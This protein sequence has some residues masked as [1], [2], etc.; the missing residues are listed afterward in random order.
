MCFRA[1]VPSVN[2]L[3]FR[4]R[5]N[6]PM[7]RFDLTTTSL[8][9]VTLLARMK[10]EH[11]HAA[12]DQFLQRYGPR[13][14]QWC[15]AK[16]LNETDAEEVAQQVLVKLLSKM[17]AFEYEPQRGRFRGWLRTVTLNTW[18]DYLRDNARH[19][20]HFSQFPEEELA[21][22]VTEE[23]D[24][25][26]FEMASEHVRQNV[27]PQTWRAFEMRAFDQ[28]P[29]RQ[30]ADELGMTVAAVNMAK[31]RVQKMLTETLRWFDD[32]QAEA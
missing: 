8:T 24:R 5:D 14:L 31:S 27:E 15:R 19:R 22:S 2:S 10:D 28:V 18:K 26:L 13:V 21:D 25:E 4:D 32:A 12:W 29:S 17:V 16:E 23:Y 20:A 30:V 9:S 11:D 3:R 1:T 7:D 6:S